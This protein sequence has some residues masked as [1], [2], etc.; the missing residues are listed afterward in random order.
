MAVH[1]PGLKAQPTLLHP[2]MTKVHTNPMSLTIVLLLPTLI[3]NLAFKML[4][5]SWAHFS[6]ATTE[7]VDISARAL[8]MHFSTKMAQMMEKDP[9][10]HKKTKMTLRVPSQGDSS[11]GVFPWYLGV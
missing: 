3:I 10:V 6:L 7:V 1:E 5:K 2:F 9:L 8:L 4:P 11:Q